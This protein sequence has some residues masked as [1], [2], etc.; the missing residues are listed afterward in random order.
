MIFSNKIHKVCPG[1]S[2]TIYFKNDNELS[3]YAF[4]NNLQNLNLSLDSK[5]N[6]NLKTLN[7]NYEYLKQLNEN[8][9]IVG[10]EKNMSV[11]YELWF[12]YLQNQTL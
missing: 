8:L 10:Y 11:I 4:N 2:V 6:S 5:G 7:L 12:N 3:I 1:D 9:F